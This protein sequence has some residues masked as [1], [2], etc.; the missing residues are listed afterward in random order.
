MKKYA[1]KIEMGWIKAVFEGD[2]AREIMDE[3]ARYQDLFCLVGMA[4][5]N[6]RGAGL[7][8]VEKLEALVNGYYGGTLTMEDLKGLNIHLSVGDFICHGIAEGEE[9]IAKLKASE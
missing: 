6:E 2:S 9:E 4:Q 5:A 3:V 7:K 1:A 8:E